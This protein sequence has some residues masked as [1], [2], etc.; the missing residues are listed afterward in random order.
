MLYRLRHD[1]SR[2]C[3]AIFDRAADALT[4]T[5]M[6]SLA[7]ARQPALLGNV[8]DRYGYSLIDDDDA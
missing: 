6:G 7:D 1:P 2:L 3:A 8:L 5:P 4:A